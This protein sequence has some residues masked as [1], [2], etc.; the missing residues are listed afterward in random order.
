MT[1]WVEGYFMPID[2][3]VLA[4]MKQFANSVTSSSF[5]AGKAKKIVDA[6]DR[7]VS[8]VCTYPSND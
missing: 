2:P 7:K 8:S 6:I 3:D 5:L 4:D 1:S